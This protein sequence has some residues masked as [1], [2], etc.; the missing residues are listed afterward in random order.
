MSIRR[1]RSTLFV[2]VR[3]TRSFYCDNVSTASWHR[4][5]SHAGHS[6][7]NL[8][9]SSRLNVRLQR[10]LNVALAAKVIVSVTVFEIEFEAHVARRQENSRLILKNCTSFPEATGLKIRSPQF[11]LPRKK[12]SAKRAADFCTQLMLRSFANVLKD[13]RCIEP[14][15][16]SDVLFVALQ[17]PLVFGEFSIMGGP[18]IERDALSF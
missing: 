14:A 4:R 15:Q 11:P 17:R 7:T 13:H 6:L 1:S 8:F 5:R 10:M 16:V 12:R 2:E 9:H 3:F 18:L